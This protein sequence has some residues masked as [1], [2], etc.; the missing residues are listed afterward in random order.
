MNSIPPKIS[1][2][3]LRFAIVAA[4][5]AAVGIA[6]VVYF[7]NPS[8]NHFYPV[9]QFHKLT[10]L[11]CPGCGATRASYALLHGDFLTALHDN[12]LFVAG[13]AAASLRGGWFGLNRLRGRPN[14]EFFPPRWL[15]PLLV[16]MAVFGVIR[17]LPWF[18]FLS[19]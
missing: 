11:N 19:P 15:V 14:G 9:C 12:A 3:L 2:L 7:F 6:V 1:P 16:M 17:N 10:G 13:L 4:S 8:A 18:A 5:A